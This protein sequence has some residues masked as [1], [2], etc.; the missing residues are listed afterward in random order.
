[1]GARHWTPRLV[2]LADLFTAMQEACQFGSAQNHSI[3]SI[4]S[5]AGGFST[6]RRNRSKT[7]QIASHSS[8]N[9][10]HCNTVLIK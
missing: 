5:M 1:M 3:K 7:D 6:R 8:I 10:M 4:N 9:F 2:V